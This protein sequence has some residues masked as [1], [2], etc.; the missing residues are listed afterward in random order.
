MKHKSV[1]TGF[2]A[3]LENPIV[4]EVIQNLSGAKQSY[5]RLVFEN[6]RPFPDMRLLDIGCGT[7]ALVKFLPEDIDYVGFDLSQAYIDKAI[8]RWGR[9]RRSFIC[10]RISAM[11]DRKLA[12]FDVAIAIGVLHHLDDKEANDL[13]VLALKSLISGG[14]LITI[15]PCFTD[16]QSRIAQF[17]ICRDRGQYVRYPAEYTELASKVFRRI[18][19]WAEFSRSR[20]PYTHHLMEC[21]KE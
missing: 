10:G 12:P 14:R 19:N 18:N 20:I 5:K 6:I 13:F 16:S 2:R 9:G 15:D 3:I 17:V 11:L 7:G 21:W 4:Y 8:A 1:T